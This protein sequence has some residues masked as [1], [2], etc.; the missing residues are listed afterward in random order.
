MHGIN[1]N[2][3]LLAYYIRLSVEDRNKANKTD[4]SDS[5]ANQRMLLQKYVEEH[6]D[7]KEMQS[8]EFVDDGE[9]GM[10]Y[11]RSAFQKLMDEVKKGTV[12]AIIVKDYSRFGRGYIDASDYLEQIFPFLG[13]RFISVNDNY[14]SHRYKYG[15]AGMIDVGFKQIMHQYYSVS[16]SQKI[17][18]AHNQLAEKGKF[19]ASYAF[20]G[21]IKSAEKYKLEIDEES[22]KT[23]RYIFNAALQG[24][25]TAQIAVEL[26]KMGVPTPLQVL[27]EHHKTVKGWQEKASRYIWNSPMVRNV[28][29]EER[30]TGTYIFGKTRVDRIGGKK[31]IHKPREEWTIVPDVFPVII[32]KEVFDKVNGKSDRKPNTKSKAPTPRMFYN[33]ICG[34]CG[35]SLTYHHSENSYYNCQEYKNGVTLSCKGNRAYESDLIVLTLQA[36]REETRRLQQQI[37]T[38]KKTAYKGSKTN[39]IKALQLKLNAI[40]SK[41]ERLFKQLLSGEITKEQNAVIYDKLE[42]EERALT[43]QLKALQNTSAIESNETETLTFLQSLTDRKTLDE[44]TI[45]LFVKQIR[46][47]MNDRIEIDL[48]LKPMNG[49]EQVITKTYAVPE[50]KG[51]RVWLYYRTWYRE[52]RLKEQRNTLIKYAAD[53]GWDIIG[54]CGDF[55]SNS[56][57]LFERIKSIAESK[58]FDILLVENINCISQDQREV[59]EAIKVMRKNKVRIVATTGTPYYTFLDLNLYDEVKGL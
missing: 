4:E 41:K 10:I 9:S 18:Y 22:A 35:M 33:I 46:V 12:K 21:Y 8:V 53:K 45:K 32:P 58:A 50:I 59:A 16:L 36:I 19:H 13:V 51:K 43:E 30:Y 23:I 44:K 17:L 2:K 29:R 56:K 34:Y 40:Q 31:M 1:D 11:E 20:Y 26:N 49:Q 27:R 55:R 54:E 14:D 3:N 15:S 57:Q 5:V 42:Q 48:T 38:A 47:F 52:E 7:L 37:Q 25:K 6:L 28:L 24:K 39:K